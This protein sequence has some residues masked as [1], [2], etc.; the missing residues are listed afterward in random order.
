MNIIYI[1]EMTEAFLK[2]TKRENEK[3]LTKVGSQSKS[4][5]L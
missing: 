5:T 4:Q 3:K 1:G 2:F